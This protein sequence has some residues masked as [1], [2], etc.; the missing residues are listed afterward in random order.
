MNGFDITRRHFVEKSLTLTGMTALASAMPGVNQMAWAAG[1]PVKVY[2]VT[3][4]Q[5]RDWSIMEKSIDIEVDYT[6]TN[7]D[8]GVF[9]RDV[10]SNDL[11]TTHDV[12]IFDGGTEDLLGPQGYYAEVIED[13]PELTLWERTS[14]AWK[15]A[16]FLRAEDKQYSV[17]VIGN[18]DAFGYFPD[19]IDAN[20]NGLDEIPWTTFFEGEEIKGRVAIDRSWLQSL[21]ETANYLK[22][23]GVVAIEDPADLTAEEARPVVD[24]LIERKQAGQFRTIFSAFEEQV[25]LLSNREVDMINCW[26]PATK[27]ANEAL[28]PTR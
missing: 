28:G 10:I 18:G 19:A 12:F 21:A 2:G 22:H 15:R 3:T 20:P 5:L 13:H 9:M 4:A 27:E 16:D 26:E 25:Q 11:G 17:P 14:D 7:A 6:P 24:F 1:E 23:H 8:I